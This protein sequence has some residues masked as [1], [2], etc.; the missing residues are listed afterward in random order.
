MRLKS[1]LLPFSSKP[2]NSTVSSVNS[3]NFGEENLNLRFKEWVDKLS[4]ED[5]DSLLDTFKL[6]NTMHETKNPVMTA[7]HS[8]LFP[9]TTGVKR[10]EFSKSSDEHKLRKDNDLDLSAKRIILKNKVSDDPFKY[11]YYQPFNFGFAP[12]SLPKLKLAEFSA[13]PI[14]WPEW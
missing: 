1:R 4:Q 6:T 9:A 13:D 8:T 12:S 5:A 14:E 3:F 11:G 7:K 10:L 2:T